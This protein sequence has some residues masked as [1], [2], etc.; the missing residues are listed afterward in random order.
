MAIYLYQVHTFALLGE[1]GTSILQ[2]NGL[3]IFCTIIVIV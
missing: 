2:S 1:K 3:L